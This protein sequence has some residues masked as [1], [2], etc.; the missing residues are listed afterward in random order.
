MRRIQTLEFK[1][2]VLILII[3]SFIVPGNIGQNEIL[4]EYKFG[5]PC[6]YLSIYQENKSG[7]QLFSN[8]FDG[9]KG[10]H[11]DILG[12]FANVFIIYALLVLIKKIYMKVDVK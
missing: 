3:I 2:S 5:F 10:I 1:L 12:F 6:D 9:N 8:L 4:I 7:C 11:I